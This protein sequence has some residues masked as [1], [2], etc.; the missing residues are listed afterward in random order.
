MSLQV[1]NTDARRFFFKTQNRKY[2]VIRVV[3]MRSLQ[4]I[5][6]KKNQL[7][8]SNAALRNSY[9][10]KCHKLLWKESTP[11][12]SMLPKID[13]TNGTFLKIL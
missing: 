2:F 13:Y 12:I 6:K 3:S 10:K 4:N 1:N 7:S 11:A 5:G 8:R 9:L